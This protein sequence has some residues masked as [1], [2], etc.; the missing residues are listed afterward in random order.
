MSDHADRGLNGRFI[1]E[2]S[3]GGVA[4]QDYVIIS[5]MNDPVILRFESSSP[6]PSP[7]KSEDYRA[8]DQRAG[9]YGAEGHGAD[10]I[11]A[12]GTTATRFPLVPLWI[13]ACLVMQ[14]SLATVVSFNPTALAQ[15]Q[16]LLLLP[17]WI[18]TMWGGWAG[19]LW[20]CSAWRSQ[21]A[22]WLLG[23]SIFAGWHVYWM[24]QTSQ[25][26]IARYV[27]MLGGYAVAQGVT[28][29][30]LCVANWRTSPLELESDMPQ[31]RQFGIAEIISI[32]AAVALIIAAGRR[33]YP[34]NGEA[35]WWGLLL[36]EAALLSIATVTALLGHARSGARRW[37]LR[38]A[39]AV[40]IVAGSG[41]ISASEPTRGP[42]TI[43]VDIWLLYGVALFTFWSWLAALTACGRSPRVITA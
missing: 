26:E 24:S 32:T 27:A 8:E 2:Q 13:T 15:F 40:L 28:F 30:L 38:F 21:P 25:H 5:E 42:P 31:R 36:A 17:L 7:D 34:L 10:G 22:R 39:A 3:S 11:D 23:I 14:V 12:F 19:C 16:N 33:Y 18:G 4:D 1:H 43:V 6:E 9:D 37:S 35:Y 29:R 20:I 41:L